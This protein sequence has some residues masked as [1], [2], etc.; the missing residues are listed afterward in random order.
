MWAWFFPHLYWNNSIEVTLVWVIGESY[1]YNRKERLRGWRGK[2]DQG[3]FLKTSWSAST[4]DHRLLLDDFVARQP[5]LFSCFFSEL[6]QSEMDYSLN[7]GFWRH[8]SLLQS[9]AEGNSAPLGH[10]NGQGIL[11]IYCSIHPY[12]PLRCADAPCVLSG[13]FFCC[14]HFAFPPFS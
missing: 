8:A 4:G 6:G 3:A 2:E 1:L 11:Y 9:L 10:L 14:T 7:F 12:R 5:L 13:P